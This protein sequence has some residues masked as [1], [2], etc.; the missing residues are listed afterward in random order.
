MSAATGANGCVFLLVGWDVID[1]DGGLVGWDVIDDDGGLVAWVVIDD[2][3]GSV[4]P[5]GKWDSKAVDGSR[6]RRMM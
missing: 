6:R 4:V 3:G 5:A 1:D 2:D